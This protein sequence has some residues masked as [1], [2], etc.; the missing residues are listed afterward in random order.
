MP[1]DLRA[2]AMPT[3]WRKAAAINCCFAYGREPS[4]ICS[5]ATRR[6]PRLLD[7]PPA[8]AARPGSTS[9]NLSAS[10]DAKGPGCAGG[11]C[12]YADASLNP[13]SGDWEK[14]EYFYRVWGRCLYNPD[15]DPEGWR[16]YL[17]SNFGP[18]AN[19]VEAALANASRVLPLVT[20]AHLASASN[21]AYWPEIYT[22]MPIVL[23][24]EDS[25]YSDTPAPKCFGTVSPLDPQLFSTINEHAGDLLVGRSN[26]KYSPVEV[27]QWLEDA[28]AASTQGLTNA[29]LQAT[30]HTSPEFRRMEEDVL[31]QIGLG[32]FFAAKLRSGVLFEIY[33][34]NR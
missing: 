20:S 15:A 8:S 24:S 2:M 1:G 28:T 11:R 26:P 22:N 32:R 33:S 34:Q 21:H 31:I 5:L 17:R 7:A 6:W 30:S 10:K 12:A 13:K 14:F 19:S 29:R 16:R 27:A 4:G 25:P 3:S 9:W 18:G 23:G